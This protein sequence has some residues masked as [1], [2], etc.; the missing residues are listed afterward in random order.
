MGKA[1]N[2]NKRMDLQIHFALVVN[3]Y[4][5]A[6]EMRQIHYQYKNLYL[7]ICEYLT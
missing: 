6:D 7:Y 1:G 4:P 5:R 3:I 2:Q